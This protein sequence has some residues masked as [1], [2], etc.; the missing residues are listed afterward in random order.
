MKNQ[1]TRKKWP[2]K[3]SA[4][5]GGMSTRQTFSVQEFKIPL[6]IEDE[7]SQLFTPPHTSWIYISDKINLYGNR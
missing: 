6:F 7:I 2:Q 1:Q 3:R 5:I 4:H